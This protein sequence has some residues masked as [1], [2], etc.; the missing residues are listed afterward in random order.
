MLE[1]TETYK[2]GEI[3][4]KAALHY[5]GQTRLLQKDMSSEDKKLLGTD[6]DELEVS[7]RQLVERLPYADRDIRRFLNEN[8]GIIRAVLTCF[9]SDVGAAQKRV[10][11]RLGEE[12]ELKT[13]TEEIDF[14]NQILAMLRA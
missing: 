12:S 1:I 10:F 9:I 2:I 5:S 8:N 6:V 4:K 14:A 11:E 3:L 7:A 13:S